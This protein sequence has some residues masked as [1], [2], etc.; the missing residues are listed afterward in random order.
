MSTGDSKS[1]RT[2]S[3]TWISI[4]LVAM[5]AGLLL[6]KYVIPTSR[7][8]PVLSG[9]TFLP[10]AK[11]LSPF[12]LVDYDGKPFGPE[13]LQGKWSFVFF[14]YTNCPDV[15]PATLYQFKLI[16]DSLGKDQ[17]L[18]DSTRFIFISGDPDR[19][20]PE[21]LKK[22]VQYYNPHFL[23]L[24]GADS[25]LRSLGREM[26]IIYLRMPNND[27]AED[28]LIDH[29]S[30]ILLT[31]P[32]GQLAAFFSAPHNANTIVSDYKAIRNYVEGN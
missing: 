25:V 31:N 29:S 2:R 18:G 10:E 19:D 21:H 12:Q 26:G 11:N 13:Q 16:A 3:L 32:A 27:N 24:T 17:H 14:G 4:A 1:T 6:A 23:G 20:T 22:Y 9:G 15:C 28:Y 7:P 5:V 30:A 8:L